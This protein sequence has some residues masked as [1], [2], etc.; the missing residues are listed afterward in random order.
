MRRWLGHNNC[1]PAIFET[2][3][4]IPGTVLVHVEFREDEDA[5]AFERAFAAVTEA[6]G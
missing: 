4:A 1:A 2:A 6:A 5:G 3:T